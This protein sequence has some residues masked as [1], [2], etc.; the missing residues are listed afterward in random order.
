MTEKNL[1]RSNSIRVPVD[2]STAAE[3]TIRERQK[4]YTHVVLTVSYQK[5]FR[6]LQN[7]SGYFVHVSCVRFERDGA[8]ERWEYEP[9]S[10]GGL[11]ICL[12]LAPR[13]NRRV[14]DAYTKALSE[15]SADIVG[16]FL[17]LTH[18]D[19]KRIDTMCAAVFAAVRDVH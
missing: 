19:P 6:A 16:T 3:P 9:L 2:P 13:F 10:S 11:L 5:N 14:L 7:R 18:D 8:Y 12:E 4:P 15:R 17:S 1:A